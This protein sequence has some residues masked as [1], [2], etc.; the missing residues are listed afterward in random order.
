VSHSDTDTAPLFG[1]LLALEV[2][3]AT[4]PGRVRQNNEDHHLAARLGR[5]LEVLATNLPE[6]EVPPRFDEAGWILVVADGMGGAEAGEVASRIAIEAGLF[7]HLARPTW[8]LRNDAGEIDRV[9]ARMRD[10]LDRVHA[11]V[12]RVAANDRSLA[13]M[14]TTLTAAYLTGANL[15]L[16]HVGDSRAYLFRGGALEQLTRDQT[17]VQQLVDQGSIEPEAAARHPL[18]HV[19]SHAV[20]SNGIERLPADLHHLPLEEADRLL[21]CSDGLSDPLQDAR[22]GQ[23]LAEAKSPREACAELL[24]AALAGG[25]PDNITCMVADVSLQSVAG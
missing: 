12:V 2:A 22:I 6:G 4:H 20:G 19:L 14:G 15:F 17:L 23:I 25:G 11:D 1:P 16:A 7:H 3:A 8:Y 10:L 21:L 18:R 5:T 13:G 9:L 24:A